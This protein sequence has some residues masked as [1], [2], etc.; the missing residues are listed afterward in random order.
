LVLGEGKGLGKEKEGKDG[1]MEE[2]DH[3]PNVFIKIC[4]LMNHRQQY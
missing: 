4:I 3:F 2:I 1:R